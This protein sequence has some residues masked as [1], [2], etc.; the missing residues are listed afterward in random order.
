MKGKIRIC[1][2]AHPVP[3]SFSHYF[4]LFYSALEDVGIKGEIVGN[5]ADCKLHR[6]SNGVNSIH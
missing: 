2:V 6:K 4:I 5:R 3:L 1:H